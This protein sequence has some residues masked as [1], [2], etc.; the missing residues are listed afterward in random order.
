MKQAVLPRFMAPVWLVYRL[1][2]LKKREEQ[3]LPARVKMVPRA[4]ERIIYGGL[5]QNA[6]YQPR[7][8]QLIEQYH[9]FIQEGLSKDLISIYSDIHNSD[10]RLA[11]WTTAKVVIELLDATTPAFSQDE[12]E[13]FSL[14][15]APLLYYHDYKNEAAEE[16]FGEA[17]SKANLPN[18]SHMISIIDRCFEAMPR[19]LGSNKLTEG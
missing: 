1:L 9:G 16:R 6:Q 7:L 14:L 4:V 3:L 11:E 13:F 10:C 17:F 19:I 5:I 2:H 18:A 12:S 8:D 15:Y